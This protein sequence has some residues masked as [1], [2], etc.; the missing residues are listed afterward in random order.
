MGV[1]AN[2]QGVVKS[3]PPCRHAS[4]STCDASASNRRRSLSWID[5]QGPVRL[6]PTAPWRSLESCQTE[7]IETCKDASFRPVSRHVRSGRTRRVQRLERWRVPPC[8]AAPRRCIP[9]ER[10][11]TYDE[12]VRTRLSN[13]RSSAGHWSTVCN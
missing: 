13:G 6:S 7:Q 3:N 5:A 9:N 2:W 4:L 12:A 11:D 10:G 1:I 8:Q